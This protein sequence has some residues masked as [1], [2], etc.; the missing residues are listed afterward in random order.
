MAAKEWVWNFEAQGVPYKVE[1]KKNKVSVNDAEPVK[2]NKLK[3]KS[4]F[5]E[6]NYTMMIEG[7]EA[8]IHI[9]QFKAPVLSYDGKDCATGKEYISTK[10]P[11]WVWIFIVLHAIDFFILI[12]GAVGGMIQVL[13]IAAI[14][15]AAS[16]TKK[17]TGVRV[18]ICAGIWLL[19]TVA[20]F[21]L[22]LWLSATL[23]R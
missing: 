17:P 4:N 21:F 1:L 3:V 13:I 9:G 16:N 11:G 22:A 6:T 2:L 7:K 15:S 12:G 20:Q 8:V 10:T 19:S 18:L 23:Y 14:A 5:L